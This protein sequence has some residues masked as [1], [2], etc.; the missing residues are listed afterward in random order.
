MGDWDAVVDVSNVCRSVILPPRGSGSPVWARLTRVMEAW[1][2]RHGQDARIT[3]VSDRNLLPKLTP[4]D[5]R[6]YREFESAGELFSEPVADP[7]ILEL[8]HDH[9]LHVISGDH[10][11]DYR[12]EHPWI[13]EM[14][15]RFHHWTA[16][17]G[18]IQFVP[19]GIRPIPQQM[20]SQ[21]RQL[22]DLKYDQ[23]LDPKDHHDRQLLTT[24]WRCGGRR[25]LHA[26]NWPDQLLTWPL[27]D[28][29]GRAVCPYCRSRLED[30]GP[31]NPL[32]EI[33]VENRSSGDEIMRFP[34]E[35][36]YPLVIGRGSAVEGI[37]LG[38]ADQVHQPA[39]MRISRA[40]LRLRLESSGGG[41]RL[42]AQDLG[43][44]NGTWIERR[45]KDGFGPARR[46]RPDEQF[47]VN[48]TDRLLLGESI[49]VRVSG[50][51][52]LSDARMPEP[53]PAAEDAGGMTVLWKEQT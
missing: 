37:N 52:Y 14:P 30:L 8:A 15:G 1:R 22:K 6:R 25:C 9:G 7:R 35:V 12:D 13:E 10:F 17:G 28:P 32:R 49:H 33:V 19:S 26:R 29:D 53:G 4:T 50:K 16:A 34:L 24:R 11:D 40:H 51:R 31:R 43:S 39:V 18:G 46:V 27:K 48:F 3:L 2:E 20:V 23:K 42:L 36:G 47:P 5:K 21:S 44:T 45:A 41:H 38:T